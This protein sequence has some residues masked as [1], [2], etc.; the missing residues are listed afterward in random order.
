MLCQTQGRAL[1]PVDSIYLLHEL[2][3]LKQWQSENSGFIETV[4]NGCIIYLIFL[5]NSVISKFIFI[6]MNLSRRRCK[7]TNRRNYVVCAAGQDQ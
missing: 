4:I 2:T 7:R 1:T 6:H 5:A 3:D